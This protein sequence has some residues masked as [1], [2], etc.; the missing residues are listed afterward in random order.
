[1]FTTQ[2]VVNAEISY[3]ME[4]ARDAARRA[5]VQRPSFF[6]RLFTKRAPRARSSVI[7]SGRPVSARI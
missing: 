6:G 1:M 2:E 7:T 4:Q 5:Q 3:R